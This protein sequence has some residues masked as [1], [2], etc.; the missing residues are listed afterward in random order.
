MNGSKA[1]DILD[2]FKIGLHPLKLKK[3]LQ[4]SMDG[5]NVNWKFLKLLKEDDDVNLIDLGSCGL[6]VVHGAFQSGHKAAKWTINEFLRGI[7][8]LFKDSPARRASFKEL[9]S[10][11]DF[12]L[13]FCS[14]RWV[15]SAVAASRA[16]TLLESLTHYVDNPNTKLPKTTTVQN[17]KDNLKDKLLKPKLSFFSLIATNLEIFLRKYQSNEPLVPFLFKDLDLIFRSLLERIIKKDYLIKKTNEL[18]KIDFD[19]NNIYCPYKQIDLGFRTK[20]F[21]K[22][23][24]ASESEKLCFL[25]DCRYF[26][27]ALIKKLIERSPLKFKAT[28]MFS[29]LDPNN[30]FNDMDLSKKGFNQLLEIFTDGNLI[31]LEIAEYA[32]CQMNIFLNN[33][34]T[35]KTTYESYKLSPLRLDKF[36]GSIFLNKLEYKDLFSIIKMVLCLSHGNADVESGFSVN[37]YMLVENQMESSLI[38]RRQVYDAILNKNGATSVEITKKMKL[39]CKNAH[40]RYT[41]AIEESKKRDDEDNRKVEKRKMVMAEIN[42]LEKKKLK[43]NDIAN[44]ESKNID[45]RLHKLR[46]EV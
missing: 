41:Q 10:T 3:L 28:K 42:K 12:P 13:K 15:E 2:S 7:Y 38:A 9:T 18:L 14:V 24:Q 35:F 45:V 31:D 46:K 36:Y 11:N 34:D 33:I 44:Y 43:I 32:M 19:D 4:V 16:I 20:K 5:P 6:H 25:R 8:W 27:S 29:C 39:Y 21:L 37:K 40:F 17:V 1:N 26:I 22:E 23:S 30:L